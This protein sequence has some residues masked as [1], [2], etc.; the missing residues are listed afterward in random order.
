MNFSS[1]AV[2]ATTKASDMKPAFISLI[3][4]HQLTTMDHENPYTHLSTFYELV[5]TMDFQPGNIEIVYLRL[6]P[7][8][9]VG[10]D[11]E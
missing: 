9:L 5:G 6:F 1:I 3:S 11:K 8:S 10:K 4:R 2:P 7:F